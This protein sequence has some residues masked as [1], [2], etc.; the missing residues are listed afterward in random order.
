MAARFGGR[1]SSG[2]FVRKTITGVDSA[3]P[4]GP[5]LSTSATYTCDVVALGYQE[6]YV[7]GEFIKKGDYRVVVLRGT[8]ELDGVASD[9]V[10][11]PGDSIN[12]PPPGSSTPAA[13]R[14][15]DVKP[16]TEAFATCQ[17][18]GVGA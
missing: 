14:V 4:A 9:V 5:P 1:L 8:V 12:C 3:N 16:I 17:V 6:R 15:V 11:N 18:R 2:S 7:D 13:A 10:P